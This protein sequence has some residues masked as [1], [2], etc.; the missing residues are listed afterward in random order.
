MAQ[1]LLKASIELMPEQT[2]VSIR[3]LKDASSVVATTAT[4]ILDCSKSDYIRV[5]LR[6][7]TQLVLTGATKDG[8]QIVVGLY[9]GDVA[10][11][12]VITYSDTVRLGYDIFSFPLLSQTVGK[13][14]RLVFMYDLF[15]D[16]YDLVGYS[17]GY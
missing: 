1:K 3:T 6:Y 14:D 5:D 15:S 8:Q 4:T 2:E 17:R 13:L 16:K 10:T 7:D 9:Q 11:T 12:H